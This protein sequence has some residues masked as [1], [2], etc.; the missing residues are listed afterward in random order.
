MQADL[1]GKVA[2]VTGSSKGIGRAIALKFAGNG[3]DIV[4]NARNQDPA[5]QVVK[6]IEGLRILPCNSHADTRVR[7][8]ATRDRE[9]APFASSVYTVGFF[10]SVA[11]RAVFLARSVA[12]GFST[13]WNAPQLKLDA[14]G[15]GSCCG[16]WPSAA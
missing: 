4:V 6:E 13:T 3:A 9:E 12:P 7:C 15:Q 16:F 10:L 2:L 11:P 5:L 1:S 8:A 14:A